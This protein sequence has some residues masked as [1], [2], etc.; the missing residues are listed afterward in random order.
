MSFSLYGGVSGPTLMYK[1][2]I[3]SAKGVFCSCKSFFFSR[4]TKTI[5][6]IQMKRTK[7]YYLQ[8]W[9]DKSAPKWMNIQKTKKMFTV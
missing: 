4:K 6:Q 7:V 3:I 9:H 5:I 1:Y 2:D 8:E